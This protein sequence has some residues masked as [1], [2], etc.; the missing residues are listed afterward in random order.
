MSSINTNIAALTALQSLTQSQKDL[1]ATQNQISTGFRVAT[2]ADNAAYWS[3]A[4]TMRSDNQALSTVSDALGLGAA[5]VS[6]AYTGINNAIDVVDQIK[7]KLVAATQPGVD[8]SKIQSD[9]TQLQSQL[10]SIANTASFSG[11]NWLSV[12]SSAAGY[13][14][15][16]GIVA[17]F[18]RSGN[19]VIVGT[20]DI[21]D[22]T[23]KLFDANGNT[24]IL[25]S[26][27]NGVSVSNMNISALTDSAADHTTL[28][29]YITQV[30]QVLTSLA[31]AATTLGSATSRIQIQQS[32]VKTLMNSIDTGVSSLVDADM[33][34]E[35]TKLQALQVKQQLG[36]QA[37]SIANASTQ[38]ILQLFR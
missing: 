21:D 13:N 24:G 20:I 27:T 37:L 7:A 32:F 36:V 23:I 30:D 16:K 15:T 3:I 2:A 35:S 14:V 8:R 28:V 19:N 38:A 17:S 10:T 5:M 6:V 22:S 1:T 9:I 12:N 26:Q 31:N 33:N 25:D 4:T 29:G 18:S 11:Q 34:A